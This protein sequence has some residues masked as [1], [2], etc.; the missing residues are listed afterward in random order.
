M[1]VYADLGYF[2]DCLYK[3]VYPDFQASLGCTFI[4]VLPDSMRG[5]RKFCLRGS[6]FDNVF[7]T[8]DE[9][10]EDPN[11]T[12]SGPSSTHQRNTIKMVFRWRADDG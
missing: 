8:V 5:S 1:L 12:I 10:G 3:L 4:I 7:S 11:N 9:W 2:M 6:N